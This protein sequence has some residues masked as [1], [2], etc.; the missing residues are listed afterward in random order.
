LQNLFSNFSMLTSLY[1]LFFSIV[2]IALFFNWRQCVKTA[3]F[4][5]IIEGALRKWVWPE[6]G[7]YIFFLKDFVLLVAY[8]KFYSSPLFLS[9]NIRR[10]EP[11]ILLFVIFSSA[12]CLIQAFNPNLGSPILGLFGVKNYLLYIPLEESHFWTQFFKIS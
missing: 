8:L 3:L 2:L 5:L 7:Y 9:K 10:K 1:I 4:I 11:W 12:M 6:Y